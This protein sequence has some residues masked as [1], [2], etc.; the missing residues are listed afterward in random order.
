MSESQKF[1]EFW[2]GVQITIH[3]FKN[4]KSNVN[5][6]SQLKK[7]NTYNNNTLFLKELQDSAKQSFHDMHTISHNFQ[8]ALKMALRDAPTAYV[9]NEDYKALL[10]EDYRKVLKEI[11]GLD[12]DYQIKDNDLETV[13]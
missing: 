9:M 1:S 12:F 8:Y 13:C 7:Q 3:N 4:I 11:I 2:N 6:L 5:Q 10:I